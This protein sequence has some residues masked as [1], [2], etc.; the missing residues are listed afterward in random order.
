MNTNSSLA[1]LVDTQSPASVSPFTPTASPASSYSAQI[2][3][4]A[5]E[6]ENVRRLAN[7]EEQKNREEAQRQ[8]EAKIDALPQAFGVADLRAVERII[9]NRLMPSSPNRRTNAVHDNDAINREIIKGATA[10]QIKEHFDLSPA[11]YYNRKK[12]LRKAGLIPASPNLSGPKRRGRS[13]GA[14]LTRN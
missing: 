8:L 7:E 2:A 11:A 10:P 1:A 6:L 9:R 3:R 13:R 14:Q 4:L 5:E 12:K